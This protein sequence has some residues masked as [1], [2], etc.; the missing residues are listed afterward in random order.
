MS[1]AFVLTMPPPSASQGRGVHLPR[2]PQGRK[3]FFAPPMT[4]ELSGAA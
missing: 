2:V 4:V 1:K 3:E